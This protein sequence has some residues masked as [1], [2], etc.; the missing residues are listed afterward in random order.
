MSACQSKPF[1]K[2]TAS[3]DI[4]QLVSTE[5]DAVVVLFNNLDAV[6]GDSATGAEGSRCTFAEIVRR[7]LAINKA[8]GKEV[9]VLPEPSVS[10]GRLVLAPTDSL[11]DDTDDVRKIR[12]AVKAGIEK[13]IAAGSR[14]PVLF[15]PESPP[16]PTE[17]PDADY[18][19]WVDVALLAALGVSYVTLMVR[20]FNE[21]RYGTNDSQPMNEKLDSICVVV[22]GHSEHELRAIVKR[23]VALEKGRRLCQ[24]KCEDRQISR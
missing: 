20:E 23:V 8:F 14:R 22:S 17:L 5:S 21:S 11:N 13:A 1:P 16:Q 6:V 3:P 12:D 4:R 19:R 2:I 7:H 10:G 9:A 15:L 24:G 18:S